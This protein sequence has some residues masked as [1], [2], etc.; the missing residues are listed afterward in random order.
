[1]LNP[2]AKSGLHH[3]GGERERAAER[4]AHPP[5][6]CS[7]CGLR[8]NRNLLIVQQSRP[9]G[10]RH[11]NKQQRG[12]ETEKTGPGCSC[13]P[14]A[15]GRLLC[16]YDIFTSRRRSLTPANRSSPVCSHTTNPTAASQGHCLRG[17]RWR[18]GGRGVLGPT[19]SG[20][21]ASPDGLRWAGAAC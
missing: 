16:V 1:M 13:R 11:E 18:G 4:C 21:L 7:P 3:R 2:C 17:M 20:A 9:R 5:S 8:Q 14:T 19:A 6:A 12:G 10:H 15:A